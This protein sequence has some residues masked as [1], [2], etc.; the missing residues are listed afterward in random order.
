MITPLQAKDF[1]RRMGI[2]LNMPHEEEVLSQIIETYA[3]LAE[4]E[5]HAE[6]MLLRFLDIGN[7]WEIGP[8]KMRDIAESTA[9]PSTDP[10]LEKIASWEAARRAA[11]GLCPI[12]KGRGFF[13]NEKINRYQ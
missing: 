10:A 2:I 11:P 7:W 3:G 4:D 5:A 12:C 9:T 8:R 6:R 13:R 1:V